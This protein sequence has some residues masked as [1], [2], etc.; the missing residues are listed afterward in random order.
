[1]RSG[2]MV[3]YAW[4]R[5]SRRRLKAV[6][7]SKRCDRKNLRDLSLSMLASFIDILPADIQIFTSMHF[8]TCNKADNSKRELLKYLI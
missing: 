5:R 6:I 7:F 2:A 4:V 8:D 3:F 1:M